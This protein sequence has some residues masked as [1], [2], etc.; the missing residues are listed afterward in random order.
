MADA[1]YV[2]YLDADDGSQGLKFAYG[3]EKLARLSAIKAV[4]D[5]ANLFRSNQNIL[6]A[7]SSSSAAGMRPSN[8]LPPA[9]T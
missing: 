4:Y 1:A 6:P 2:N 5:P 3:G 9:S 7:V 8:R